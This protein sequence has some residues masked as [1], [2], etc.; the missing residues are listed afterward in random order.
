MV[1]Y[2]YKVKKKEIIMVKEFK[3][4]NNEGQEVDVIEAKTIQGATSKLRS[5][6]GNIVNLL[7]LLEVK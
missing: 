4:I 7:E 3:V 2:N 1:Y 6:Y 5:V